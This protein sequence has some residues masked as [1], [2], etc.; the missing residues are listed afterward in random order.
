MHILRSITLFVVAAVAEIGGACTQ[1]HHGESPPPQVT[2]TAQ[3][4]LT[5]LDDD[6]CGNDSPGFRCAR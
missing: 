3:S 6:D 4:A 2:T 5:S 1:F